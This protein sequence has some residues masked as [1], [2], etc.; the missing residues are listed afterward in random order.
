MTGSHRQSKHLAIAV[1][2]VLSI[3]LS[4]CGKKEEISYSIE[5]AAPQHEHNGHHD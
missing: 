3:A 4:A 2:L 1:F 5:P